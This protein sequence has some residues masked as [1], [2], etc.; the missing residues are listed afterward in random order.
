MSEPYLGQIILVAFNFAPSGY[1]PCDGRLLPI[2]DYDALFNVLGTTYGGD[3]VT[4]FA[5]PDLR[6]RI[7]TGFGAGTSQTYVVGAV[8]GNETV[9][10]GAAQMPAHTH[11]VVVNSLAATARC[12]NGA[13]NHATPVGHVPAIGPPLPDPPLTSHASVIQA[14][15]I[16]DL[17]ARVDAFRAGAGL[18]AY[19]YSDPVLTTG[20]TTIQARHVTEL[21]AALVEAYAARG[22]TPPSFTDPA[23]GSG[24]TVKAAHITELRNAAP[25][26]MSTYS[27]AMPNATMHTSAVTLGGSPTT[28]A[29]GGGQ[30]HNNIQ[31]SLVMNYCIAVSGIFPS[32]T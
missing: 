4:T 16:A 2:F 18:G 8:G 17:R 30:S 25:N 27:G 3:G 11:P 19:S 5:V 15:H 31:P 12:K 7:P 22:L 13:G 23:L 14:Q 32:P 6:G 20:T 10:L 24:T 21:R 28:A 9:T 29:A 1:V 26:S